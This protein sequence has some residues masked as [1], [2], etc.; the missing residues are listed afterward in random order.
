MKFNPKRNF[1]LILTA[2]FFFSISPI[3]AQSGMYFSEFCK[4]LEMYFHPDLVA[5]IHKEM[6]PSDFLVWGWDVG[7]FSGD[8]NND[9]AFSIRRSGQKDKI[10][11]VYLFVDIDGFLTKVGEFQVNYFE[12][13]LEVGVAIRHN[14]CYVTQKFKQFNWDIKSYKFINNV[15]VSYD[16]YSTRRIGKITQETCKNFY[17]LRNTERYLN[18]AKN[19]TEFWADYLA[20]PSYSRGRLVYSGFSDEASVNYIEYVPEGAY[21]LTGASDLSY[22]VNSVYD[23]QYLYFSITVQDDYVVTPFCDTCI[24][25]GIEIWLDVYDYKDASERLATISNNVPLFNNQAKEGIYKFTIRAGDFITR[26]PTVI[27][28]SST[29]LTPIQKVASRGIN[30]ICDLNEKGYFCI[31]KIPFTALGRTNAPIANSEIVEWGCT[32]KV[33]DYDNEFRPEERT[34]MTTS[35]FQED[36]PSTYGSL[37]FIPDEKWYGDIHNVLQAKLVNDLKE[38]GF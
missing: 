4:R 20:I 27:M 24:S 30:V 18:T 23:D 1:L 6:P 29:E 25:E 16:I 38:F 21:W 33:I 31:L 3:F 35:I 14:L 12:L 5:D 26:Q 10:I 11:D 32:V 34:V 17:N 8:D 9:V 2:I 36:N 37:L 22:S 13:P 15:L 28:S 7:D 19:T